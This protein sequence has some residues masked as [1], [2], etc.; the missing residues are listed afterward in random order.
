MDWTEGSLESE[1]FVIDTEDTEVVESGSSDVCGEGC[2]MGCGEDCD[3][4]SRVLACN[5]ACI[6]ENNRPVCLAE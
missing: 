5:F 1:G 3:S 4:G 2:G 6:S